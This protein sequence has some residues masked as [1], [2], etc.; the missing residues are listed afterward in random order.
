MTIIKL[1]EMRLTATIVD[2]SPDQIDDIKTKHLGDEGVLFEYGGLRFHGR[3]SDL[4][5]THHVPLITVVHMDI[6]PFPHAA[7]DSAK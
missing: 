6:I 1:S 5:F 4:R 2:A 7:R 3:I